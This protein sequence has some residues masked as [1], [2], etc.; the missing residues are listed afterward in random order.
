MNMVSKI[1]VAVALLFIAS[2][3][4][5]QTT[6]IRIKFANGRTGKPLPVKYMKVGGGGYDLEGYR[7]EKVEQYAL[8]VTFIDKTTFSFSNEGYYRCDTRLQTSPPMKFN[9]HEITDHGVVAPNICGK[10]NDKPVKGELLIY[11]R[12]A[13]FWEAVG[14]LRGLFICG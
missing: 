3:A 14:N 11:S 10:T 5:A 4:L 6:T 2:A 7:V 8:V 9:L 13:H 12:H 1:C